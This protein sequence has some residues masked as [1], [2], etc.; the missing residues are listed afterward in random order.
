MV[1]VVGV[2]AFFVGAYVTSSDLQ[3]QVT[4]DDLDDAMAKLELRM[5]QS[6]LSDRQPAHQQQPQVIQISPDDDPIIGDIDAPI[7]IIEFSDFQ[8]PFCARFSAQTLPILQ[9]EYIDRGLVKLVFRD[10]PI[11]NIHPNA[12][13]TAMASECANDQNRFKE[14]HDIIFENQRLWSSHDPK[15]MLATLNSYAAQIQLDE[16]EF[17]ECISSADHI[18]EIRKDLED[19]RA[20]GVTG[21][22]GFFIG[23]DEI[24]YVPIQGAQPFESFKRVI[25]AQLGL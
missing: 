11:Q 17:G 15:R 4:K 22:P 2:A 24:G 7:M 18:D 3:D 23:N 13:I 1:V 6:Q 8:C 19:G 10:F 25:D 21:T 5:L 12:V 20:Y 9:E 14:M 16:D